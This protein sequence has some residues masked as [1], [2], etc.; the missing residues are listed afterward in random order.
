MDLFTTELRKTL[1]RKDGL[2]LM[3]LCLWPA[4]VS[5]GIRSGSGFFI[6]EGIDIG[7][8]E[9]VYGQMVFQQIIFLPILLIIYIASMTFF[10]EIKEKQIYL[11]KDIPRLKVLHSKYLS[12]YTTYFIFLILY[13]ASSFFFFYTIYKGADNATPAFSANPEGIS[14]MVFDIFQIVL[15]ILFYI[16]IGITLSLKYSTGFTVFISLILYGIQNVIGFLGS[17][18]YFTPFGYTEIIDFPLD[19][20]ALILLISVGVWLLY[21]IP[22]YIRNRN[23]FRRVDFN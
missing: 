22:L 17:I 1:K 13:I 16:H 19:N 7:A 9:F 18:K 10:K 4:L 2:L 8:M 15:L 12:V 3:V 20:G 21:N 14:S 11:Y 23:Y 6:L 5:L